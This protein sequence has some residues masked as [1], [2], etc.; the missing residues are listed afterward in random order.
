MINSETL[1]M[2]K[3]IVISKLD[4]AK[5]QLETGIR[6]YFSNG[7]PVS[8]HTL[9]AAAYNVIRD[10]N[11]KRG[12][13]PMLVKDHMIEYYAKPEYQKKVRDKINEAENFFKH[14]D[15]DHETTLDFNP[16]QSEYFLLD[17]C[18]QYYKL[19][20]EFPPLFQIYQGWFMANHQTLFDLPE[21]QKRL[22][23][24]ATSV[25]P[26]LELGR[27]GYFNMMLPLVMGIRV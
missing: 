5:R 3:G 22:L 15:R 9:I 17:A 13:A 10:V 4:A 14:A 23:A 27:M 11:E 24:L 18:S 1:S 16:D 8:I 19:T 26:V 2:K 7:D 21:E 25:V 6:L 12:G 20:G